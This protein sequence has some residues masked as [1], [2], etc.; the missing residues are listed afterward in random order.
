MNTSRNRHVYIALLQD[1]RFYVGMTHLSPDE[2]ARRHRR[3]WGGIF[4]R[5]TGLVRLVW[6][7]AHPSADSARKRERQLKGWSH[8]K[9]Q[10]LI[11]GDMKRLKKLSRSRSTQ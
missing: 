7:E 4:T 6:S 5:E 11:D 10:A 1:G 3:G 9:K 2:R 8:A